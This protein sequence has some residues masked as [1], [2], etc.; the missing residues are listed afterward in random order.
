MALKIWGGGT[1]DPPTG[2]DINVAN[3]WTGDAVPIAGDD[4]VFNG[5]HG[6]ENATA[7]MGT[8]AAVNQR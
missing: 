8:W 7:S 1:N 4:V 6:N 3:N 2:N 5:Q